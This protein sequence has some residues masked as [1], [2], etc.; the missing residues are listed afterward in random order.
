MGAPIAPKWIKSASST[1]NAKTL[2]NTADGGYQEVD[3]LSADVKAA[4][5]G[6]SSPSAE[7]PFATVGDLEESGADDKTVKASSTDETP[8]YLDAKVDGT[9]LEVAE[10]KLRLKSGGHTHAQSEISGLV[11]ALA[12]KA[13]TAAATTSAAGLMSAADKIR[14]DALELAALTIASI[15]S[16]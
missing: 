16:Y 10:D 12:A 3:A 15:E 5:A 13:G 2:E 11:D 14:L 6:A 1:A 8:G 7:N 9:T 4:L